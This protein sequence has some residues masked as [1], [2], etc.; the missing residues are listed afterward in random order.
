M[1][2]IKKECAKANKEKLQDAIEKLPEA[3]RAAVNAC[4]NASQVKDK[5]GARYTNQW[6]YECLLVRIKSPSTYKH[7][8]ENK[9]LAMP[10]ENTL[11][12]Y[13]KVIKGT[14]GFDENVFKV[15]K[16]KTASM[17]S[18]DVRGK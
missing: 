4:F 8:R 6:I 3:Q 13:I 1:T 7:L 17:S 11:S 15:L 18:T 12:S 5:R 14:Y 16:S 9:V 10:S 2:N